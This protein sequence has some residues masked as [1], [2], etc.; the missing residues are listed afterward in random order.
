MKECQI[1]AEVSEAQYFEEKRVEVPL[2]LL[3][4]RLVIEQPA[5]PLAFMKDFFKIPQ[6][7]F[8]FVTDYGNTGGE[9]SQ[10]EESTGEL[11]SV[12]RELQKYLQEKGAELRSR[13]GY[14]ETESYEGKTDKAEWI[15]GLR[16]K[17]IRDP[18]FQNLMR[19]DQ[20]KLGSSTME[21]GPVLEEK[22]RNVLIPN[23]AV[24]NQT[25]KEEKDSQRDYQFVFPVFIFGFVSSFKDVVE[26]VQS[27]V[28]ISKIVFLRSY[29]NGLRNA[30]LDSVSEKFKTQV[31]DLMYQEGDVESLKELAQN[32]MRVYQG[33][34]KL[35]TRRNI[36][37]ISDQENASMRDVVKGLVKHLDLVPVNFRSLLLQTKRVAQFGQ[38]LVLNSENFG[39]LF[40]FH[41]FCL[42]NE[43]W[44]IHN[45]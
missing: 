21:V 29:K 7:T 35:Q 6:R 12:E 31:R 26:M 24:K 9:S 22:D 27:Q 20:D 42:Y 16:Y 23:E 41:S 30:G 44:I 25:D 18:K 13:F 11:T 5:D 40:S 4:T 17:P 14:F 8:Y 33:N 2:S 19:Y 28:H 15:E 38:H 43:S 36:L 3:L 39:N 45:L 32:L 34:N 10:A 1:N 37:L